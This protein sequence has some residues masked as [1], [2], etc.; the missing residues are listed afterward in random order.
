MA[1]KLY[2]G[3]TPL[4]SQPSIGGGL[5][6]RAYIG[7]QLA[8]GAAPIGWSFGGVT[9]SLLVSYEAMGVSDATFTDTSGN[10]NNGS[11]SAETNGG[12]T[13]T[14]DGDGN[15]FTLFFPTTADTNFVNSNVTPTATT[16][17]SSDIVF[18]SLGFTGE[19]NRTNWW[20]SDNEAGSYPDFWNRLNS[21]NPNTEIA[22]YLG[23][24]SE[25]NGSYTTELNKWQHVCITWN[26]S[27]ITYYLNGSQIGTDSRS[28]TL[29]F[30]ENLMLHRQNNNARGST[31]NVGTAK[32]G[33]VTYYEKTL[34]AGEVSTNYAYFQQ[35]Y[36]GL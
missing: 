32:I 16:T 8:Y 2:K 3:T 25:E 30:P 24:S 15:F 19:L 4:L 26:G 23:P 7:G 36:T 11:K 13:H 27:T 28:T 29:S 9:D 21:G 14:T 22:I 35:Y 33:A 18:Q 6:G 17:Y 20:V 31:A 34:S 10:G 1:T 12:I 5:M